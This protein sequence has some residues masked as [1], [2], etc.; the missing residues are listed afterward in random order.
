MKSKEELKFLLKKLFKVYNYNRTLYEKM[1]QG[2]KNRMSTSKFV[3]FYTTDNDF[4]IRN[5][6][7]Y[8]MAKLF[9]REYELL[10]EKFKVPDG[11]KIK[12][13]EYF[14][15]SEINLA[16]AYSIETA[17]ENEDILILKN[18]VKV[19]ED[20]FVC[21][22]ASYK[23]ISKAY[24]DGVTIYNFE[25]Q[26]EPVVEYSP[27]LGDMI[28]KP[29][30]YPKTIDEI[31]QSMKNHEFVAN[32]ITWN[33]LATG[34]EQFEYN[35]KKNELTFKRGLYSQINSIDGYHRTLA[36]DRI[37]NEDPDFEGYM[38]IKI[39]NY[40]VD[41]ARKFIQQESKG[42][43]ISPARLAGMKVSKFTRLVQHINEFENEETNLLYHKIGA[44]RKEV[45]IAH[46]RYVDFLTLSTAIESVYGE[47]INGNPRSIENLKYWLIEFFNELISIKYE[48]FKN[49]NEYQDKRAD[50]QSN[51]FALYV[52]LSKK[53]Y[54]NPEWK[55]ILKTFV[56]QVNWDLNENNWKNLLIG[57]K[58][59]DYKICKKITDYTNSLYNDLF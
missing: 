19:A 13:T 15:D 7:L 30:I 10:D 39:F 36:I 34:E 42:N 5:E 46:K 59:F 31:Y 56:Q 52:M 48:Y 1:L 6:E 55:N 22:K 51:M 12:V 41:K 40:N 24:N 26:R 3:E 45:S 47:T 54:G 37:I 58:R 57:S 16:E 21:Y 25:T 20:E 4:V 18:V 9:K 33:I 53:L 35:E 44:E 43:K 50:I 23:D 17:S 14:T 27:I 38:Q 8:W 2:I 29:K 11:K 49:A 32:M 28:Y